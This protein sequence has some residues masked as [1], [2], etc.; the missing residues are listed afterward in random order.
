MIPLVWAPYAKHVSSGAFSF[1]LLLLYYIQTLIRRLLRGDLQMQTHSN[2]QKTK[3]TDMQGAD[4]KRCPSGSVD[5]VVPGSGALSCSLLFGCYLC[6]LCLNAFWAVEHHL[7]HGILHQRGET[8]QQASNE[9]DVDSLDVGYFRQLWGQGGTLRGQREHWEDA[10]MESY[11]V[12][13]HSQMR[14]FFVF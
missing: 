13:H 6:L 7:N 4:V 5:R 9:P 1:E 10:C 8:K 11:I 3:Y 12:S 14:Y 2:D